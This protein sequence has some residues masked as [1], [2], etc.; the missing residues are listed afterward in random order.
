[1]TTASFANCESKLKSGVQRK[2]KN[3]GRTVSV[4]DIKISNKEKIVTEL[5]AYFNEQ[6]RYDIDILD[7]SLASFSGLSRETGNGCVVEYINEN[8]KILKL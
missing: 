3:S 1:M 2:L 5:G 8:P 4:S 6:T 7:E